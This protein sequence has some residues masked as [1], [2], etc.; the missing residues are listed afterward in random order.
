MPLALQSSRAYFL[1]MVSIVCFSFCAL[2]RTAALLPE[3]W[4]NG[5]YFLSFITADE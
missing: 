2:S 4:G 3:V 5:K 1:E